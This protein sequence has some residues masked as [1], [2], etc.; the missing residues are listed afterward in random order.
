MVGFSHGLVHRIHDWIRGWNSDLR[1]LAH[2][3]HDWIHDWDLDWFATHK[4]IMIG[5]VT[6]RFLAARGDTMGHSMSATVRVTGHR[7]NMKLF[8]HPDQKSDV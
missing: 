2:R 3:I 1:G 4:K 6:F 8:N 5:L 7:G